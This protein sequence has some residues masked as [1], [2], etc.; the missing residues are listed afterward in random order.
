MSIAASQKSRPSISIPDVEILSLLGEGRQSYVYKARKGSQLLAVKIQKIRDPNLQKSEAI[1]F[2]REAAFLSSLRDPGLPEIFDVGEIND[3]A[4]F[5]EQYIEG[6]NLRQI[7]DRKQMPASQIVSLAKELSRVFVKIHRH[8]LVHRDIK[9]KNILIDSSGKPYLIDF[10][11]AQRADPKKTTEEMSGT[12]LYSSPEQAGVIDRAIDARS[13][14]YSFGVVLF[15]C[16]TGQVP[17]Q[18]TNLAELVKMHATQKP[19]CIR[20]SRPD[21]PLALD[22]IIQKLLA[23]DPDDRYPSA[24][25]LLLDLENFSEIERDLSNGQSFVLGTEDPLEVF[26][27]SGH[28]VGRRE[29]LSQILKSWE[30][31]QT[32]GGTVLMV[33]GNS[34]M[35]K[36]RLIRELMKVAQ[37]EG[38]LILNGKCSQGGNPLPFSPLREAVESYLY[39]SKKFSPTEKNESDLRFLAAVGENASLLKN[40]TPKLKEL[41]ADKAGSEASTHASLDQFYSVLVDFLLALPREFGKVVLFIDDVQWL[42]DATRTIFTYLQDRLAQSKMLIVCTSRNEQESSQGLETFKKEVKKILSAQ[43]SLKAFSDKE[44]E[45]LISLQLGGQKISQELVQQIQTRSGGNPFAVGE[46]VRSLM[47]AGFLTPSW[48]TWKLD[49]AG[50]QQTELSQNVIDLVLKRAASLNSQTKSLLSTAGLWGPKFPISVMA[51]ICELTP[52]AKA[53]CIAEALQA[54]LIE[55]TNHSDEFSFIHDRVQEAFAASLSPE[56]KTKIHQQMAECL[57]RQR[58]SDDEYVYELADHYR[59]GLTAK[60]PQRV[61]E[62]HVQAGKKALSE[63]AADEAFHYF[64]R[65]QDFALE[66]NLPMNLEFKNLRAESCVLIGRYAEALQLLHEILE[67]SKEPI[68]RAKVHNRLARLYQFRREI[69]KSWSHALEGLD[70]L[71]LRKKGR[72]IR[73]AL[74]ILFDIFRGVLMDQLSIHLK[75]ARGEMLEKHQISTELYEVGGVTAYFLNDPIKFLSVMPPSIYP[76]MRIGISKELAIAY[77]AFSGG[78]GVLG[79]KKLAQQYVKKSL[80]VATQIGDPFVT[81]RSKL[82]GIY[83]QQFAGEW[84]EARKNIAEVLQNQSRYL[85]GNDFMNATYGGTSCMTMLS[86]HQNESLRAMEKAIDFLGRVEPDEERR[87]GHPFLSTLLQI[88]PGFGRLAEASIYL[89]AIQ[90][91]VQSSPDDICGGLGF[92]GSLLGFYYETKET[93]HLIDEAIERGQKITPV[94][95]PLCMPHFKFFYVFAAYARF[96][97]YFLASTE[98]EKQIAYQKLILQWKELRYAGRMP[99]WTPI[100][101]HAL[102]IEGIIAS[103]AGNG[104]KAHWA[105]SKALLWAEKHDLPLVQ[106]E[107]YRHKAHL[108][109]SQA[110]QEQALLSA[111]LALKIAL[112]YNWQ[113]KITWIQQE[114]GIE[115]Q[116]FNSSQE[117]TNGLSLSSSHVSNTSLGRNLRRDQQLSS[118]IQICMHSIG[119][120]DVKD[121]ARQLLDDIIEFFG[122]DR[123][124]IFLNPNADIQKSE[125]LLGRTMNQ[126]EL[127]QAENFSTKAI[128]RA[129]ELKAPFILNHDNTD[130]PDTSESVI[131][132]QLRSILVAPLIFREQVV[133]LIYLDNK[134]V[135]GLF[136]ERD[137]L[138][139]SSAANILAAAIEAARSV[140]VEL[141]KKDLERDLQLTGAVQGLLLPQESHFQSGSCQVSGYFKSAAQAGG[142][143]WWSETLPDGSLLVFLGD[144]TG[145]GAASAMV[146]AIV[147]GIYYTVRNTLLTEEVFQKQPKDFD[148]LS[149]IEQFLYLADQNLSSHV[150]GQFF[151]AYTALHLSTTNEL[152]LWGAGS[153]PVICVTEEEVSPENIICYGH[154]LGSGKVGEN[155]RLTKSTFR[156]RLLLYS[157]GLLEVPVSANRLFSE[158]SLARMTSSRKDQELLVFQKEVASKVEEN[159]KIS[160]LKDDVSFVM[161][162]NRNI[163]IISQKKVS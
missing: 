105:F 101:A 100:R 127:L 146:T 38:A 133:G 43:F 86:G 117:P 18:S 130:N 73:N 69:K 95:P 161:I 155:Q 16:A 94:H 54:H 159:L 134:V 22:A 29:E 129:Y 154:L 150:E 125:F 74:R 97:Q 142:D 27:D 60:N 139:I 30:R 121:Q 111:Q 13:D 59:L 58:S 62:T 90:K 92:N 32:Q 153:P 113:Q 50:L 53:I 162:D 57:E 17:F 151:M 123:G 147:A 138:F 64:L 45:E 26:H 160:A 114:F 39:R 106:Y 20:E 119:L 110:H 1:H 145:H 135:K 23:K 88:Y 35:G 33:E 3:T 70:E 5:I 115:P 21:L 40:L 12:F 83:C 65:A 122:A 96:N 103:I 149:A 148:P 14:L 31:V 66:K 136:Q 71:G 56:Q 116:S 75:P 77:A 4:F 10:G 128:S 15:E 143:W 82:L 34:G 11:L 89:K 52:K 81:V 48:G 49:Q 152:T 137:K 78:L 55:P 37:A 144:V 28:L 140:K 85:E 25:S 42:D 141:E 158:N 131:S 24:E 163:Q 120:T 80:A 76:A 91:I 126:G 107:V 19:K 109:Q 124:F 84:T 51:E 132:F 104:K 41:L 102:V 2:K 6:T 79:F 7:L 63:F 93:S 99:S 67:N 87:Q 61:F 46:F 8:G 157:D 112:Q 118:L 156:G 72:P 98:S 9:S 108:L 44:T 68:A 47:D 36:T